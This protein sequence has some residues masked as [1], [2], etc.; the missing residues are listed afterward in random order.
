MM[1]EESPEPPHAEIGHEDA[2]RQRDDGHHCAADMKQEHDADHGD[3]QAFLDRGGLQRRD[4]TI[5]QL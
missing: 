3:D 5:D 4:G 1:L 2:E